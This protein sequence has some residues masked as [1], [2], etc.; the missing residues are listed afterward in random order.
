[1]KDGISPRGSPEFIAS[2]HR[3]VKRHIASARDFTTSVDHEPTC[4]ERVSGTHR[5]ATR[6]RQRGDVAEQHA[7][8]MHSQGTRSDRVLQGLMATSKRPYLPLKI[9]LVVTRKR[10]GLYHVVTYNADS[11]ERVLRPGLTFRFPDMGFHGVRSENTTSVLGGSSCEIRLLHLWS[12]LPLVR[13]GA[14]TR[15]RLWLCGDDRSGRTSSCTRTWPFPG[16][17]T[18]V[19][20]NRCCQ[21]GKAMGS[22]LDQAASGSGTDRLTANRLTHAQAGQ[23]CDAQRR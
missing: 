12:L 10:N 16:R 5:V 4:T 22:E 3:I 23:C 11:R 2:P 14:I 21:S 18:R 6:S 8:E 20:G 9:S 7:Q 1:M 13:T 19:D 17:R 15:R